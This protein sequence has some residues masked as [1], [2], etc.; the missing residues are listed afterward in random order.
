MAGAGPLTV[1]VRTTA[2]QLAALDYVK[3]QHRRAGPPP[4]DLKAE[5][6]RRALLGSSKVYRDDRSGL[7]PSSKPKVAWPPR[8][9]VRMAV[10]DQCAAADQQRLQGGVVCDDVEFARRRRESGVRRPCSDPAR[11]SSPLLYGDSLAKLAARGLVSFIAEFAELARKEP[12]RQG[13]V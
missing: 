2:S 12:Q 7:P 1:P 5:G 11:I 10:E 4:G 9:S 3:D 6:A 13:C 8:G